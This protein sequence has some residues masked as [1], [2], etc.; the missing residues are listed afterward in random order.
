[1]SKTTI[2]AEPN[3]QEVIINRVFGAPRELVSHMWTDAAY[4]PEWWGPSKMS[5]MVDSLE[6]KKGGIWRYIS[7]DSEGNK[8]AYNGVFHEVL[9][10]ERLVHTYEFEGVPAV[11]LVTV[12]FDELPGNRT[13]LTETTIYPSVEIRDGA[14]QSGMTEGIVELMDRF[15]LLLNKHS[16]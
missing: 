5:T 3:K 13:N 15:A 1:M 11:G 6:A 10:P 8:Y 7:Q 16:I 4:I 9:L 2:I 14:L 12:T